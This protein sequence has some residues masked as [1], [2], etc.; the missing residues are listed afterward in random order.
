MKRENE[1][2]KEEK[3]KENQSFRAKIEKFKCTTTRQ[4]D[5]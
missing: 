3:D 1:E 5:K 2:L 4:S